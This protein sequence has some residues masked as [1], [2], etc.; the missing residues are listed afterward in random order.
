MA[1]KVGI[2]GFGRIGRNIFRAAL[3]DPAIEVVAVNDIT[4]AKTLAYLLKHD[5]ILGN[6]SNNVTHTDD[7]ISVD[8]KSFKVFKVKDPA[9]LDWASVGAS[10][11]V[12]S[13]GLFTKGPDAKKHLRGPVKKVIISAPAT[14]VDFTVV[15]GVN[16]K[17]YDPAKH[18]VISNAS[19]TTNC[20]APVA[21]VL[22]DNFGIS[23]GT[24]TT[25]HSYTN[26]QKLLDLPHKDLRRARAAALSM[27]PT[28]TG[29]AKALHLVIPELKGKLD[30][31]AMRVPTPN[32]S[33]VDLT[34]MTEKPVTAEGV[35]AAF[36]KAADGPMKGILGY[37]EDEVVSIDFRGDSRSSIVDAGYTR[38]VGSNCLKVLSWYDNEWG[39]SCRC[40]DLIKMLAQKL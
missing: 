3:G 23:V 24:M 26:D 13:T 17:A 22:Q 32:V 37:T 35:N 19:C 4:D 14:D 5:S 34:V 12:E 2:N 18:N 10:I 29:A 9:E 20:L 40:R 27:I 39:Y 30:G 33:V 21:K 28:S 36:K 1:V 8:G 16:D 25:I 31:Y 15:L 11:V 38:V 7:T 6:L